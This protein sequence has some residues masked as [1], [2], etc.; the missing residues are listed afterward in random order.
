V[1][2]R[3]IGTDPLRSAGTAASVARSTVESSV[4]A[5]D[6]ILSEKTRFVEKHRGR[7]V[8]DA[9]KARALAVAKLRE[10]IRAVEQAR[11]EAIAAL[12]IEQWAKVF[13]H[14][15]AG[16]GHLRLNLLKGGRLSKAM[17]NVTTITVA[18]SVLQWLLDD[19][20]WL[21]AVLA[22]EAQDRPLDPHERAIW[23]NS[24]EGRQAMALANQ[25]IAEGL[26]PRAVHE[27]EWL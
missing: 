25:R 14:E 11:E 13:P 23:E 1:T 5:E 22:D 6:R 3:P 19:A 4:V 24:D 17:P 12:G 8:N 15:D 16:A 10:A 20:A 7:L 27:A 2:R 26:K 18:T 9:S 21:G